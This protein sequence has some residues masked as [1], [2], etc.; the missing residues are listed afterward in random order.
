MA[1]P[2]VSHQTAGHRADRPLRFARGWWAGDR[3]R[4]LL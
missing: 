3:R 1:V 2:I 4:G